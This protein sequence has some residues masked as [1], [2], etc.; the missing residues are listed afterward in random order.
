MRVS[1]HLH[2]LIE[3]LAELDKDERLRYIIN[4]CVVE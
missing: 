1:D 4:D 3:K 2:S